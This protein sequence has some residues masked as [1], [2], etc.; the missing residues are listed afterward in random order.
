MPVSTQNAPRCSPP[1]LICAGLCLS[2]SLGGCP[3]QLL[4]ASE[5]LQAKRIWRVGP[6]AGCEA[7]ALPR[8]SSR[9][10]RGGRASWVSQDF[11]L[12]KPGSERGVD[13][14]KPQ[15]GPTH[16]ASL[17]SGCNTREEKQAH[18]GHGSSESF[19]ISPRAEAGHALS[20][21]YSIYSSD[22]TGSDLAVRS[23]KS[24]LRCQTE[25]EGPSNKIPLTQWQQT[26][27]QPPCQRLAP[28]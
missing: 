27:P 28:V 1:R 17:C 19:S 18:L 23:T 26:L 11:R 12:V 10:G 16:W 4:A 8:G 15:R 25:G 14:V 21:I 20:A 5:D 9:P 24:H 2:R 7:M 6:Q 13:L 22:C 3:A